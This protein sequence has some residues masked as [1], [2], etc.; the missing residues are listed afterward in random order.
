M[1]GLVPE[2][3]SVRVYNFQ[4]NIV[5]SA[6]EIMGAMG[7]ENTDEL[8]PWH[9]MRRTESY[10]I[11]NYSEI[12]DFL[13]PGDLLNEPLPESYARAVQASKAES[14]NDVHPS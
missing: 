5:K 7:L 1:V 8:K 2:D 10:E 14:F 11:R 9:L 6:C 12:Y 3:K 4:K 13:N